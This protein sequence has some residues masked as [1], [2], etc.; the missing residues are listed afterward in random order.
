MKYFADKFEGFY[1]LYIYYL[2][3]SRLIN[4][5]YYFDILKISFEYLFD[6]IGIASICCGIIN[7]ILE[8]DTNEL[9]KDTVNQFV[10]YISEE[11]IQQYI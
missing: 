11:L 3:Q 9:Y 1:L 2:L 6:E 8:D 10:E 5:K 4:Y 7:E